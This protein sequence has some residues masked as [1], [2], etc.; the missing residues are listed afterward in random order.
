MLY[1]YVEEEKT[2][3]FDKN[4]KE[5][6]VYYILEKISE[7]GPLIRQHVAESFGIDLSTVHR[8][9]NSLI[10]QGIIELVKQNMISIYSN[11]IQKHPHRYT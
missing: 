3:R 6:I 2:M 8:Y 11:L 7:G 1:A 9:I 4:K 5:A 10:K